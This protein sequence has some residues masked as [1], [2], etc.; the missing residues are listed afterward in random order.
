M[1]R[2]SGRRGAKPDGT[3]TDVGTVLL[4]ATETVTGSAVANW[5]REH[6][7]RGVLIRPHLVMQRQR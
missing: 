2:T 5:F 1:D 7:A 4:A 6:I 3:E